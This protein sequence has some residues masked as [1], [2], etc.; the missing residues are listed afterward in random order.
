MPSEVAM[1]MRCRRTEERSWKPKI[2]AARRLLA[3]E[4]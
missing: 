1:A 2:D 4:V 3:D